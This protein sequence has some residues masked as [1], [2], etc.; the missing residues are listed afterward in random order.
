MP[1]AAAKNDAFQAR[2]AGRRLSGLV[3]HQ[4]A[5]DGRLVALTGNY[6]EVL[7]REGEES[8]NR[9]VPVELKRRLPDGRWEGAVVG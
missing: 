5:E 6:L 8:V 1:W 9:I 2:F 3:L 4:R 7:V